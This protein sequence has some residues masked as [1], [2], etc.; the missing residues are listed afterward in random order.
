MPVPLK[1]SVNE[2]RENVLNS[3]PVQGQPAPSTLQ[4][5]W[6]QRPA[7]EPAVT[8]GEITASSLQWLN[9]KCLS[10][11][12]LPFSCL[13]FFFQSIFKAVAKGLKVFTHLSASHLFSSASVCL[14]LEALKKKKKLCCLQISKVWHIF[15]ALCAILNV[16]CLWPFSTLAVADSDGLVLDFCQMWKE[17]HLIGISQQFPHKPALNK[18]YLCIAI[19]SW[20]I[21]C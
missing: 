15:W 10:R 1:S 21:S 3:W 9:L 20:L 2:W 4:T 17:E 19:K 18:V 14:F 5:P 6:L 8:N 12:K 7:R 13:F 11:I 16:G